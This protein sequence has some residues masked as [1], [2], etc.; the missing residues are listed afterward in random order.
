MPM[1]FALMHKDV[2]VCELD[3]VDG[4]LVKVTGVSSF[5]H[6]PLG[7][8]HDGVVDRGRVREWWHGRSIPASRYG[9]AE[10]L[11]S[12][13]ISNPLELLSKSMGLSLSDHYWISSEGSGIGWSDVNFY[14]HPFSDDV[15]DILFGNAPADGRTIDMSSPDNTSDGQLR[16]RWKIVNGERRLI[17]GGTG[18]L[19]QEPFNEAIA[20]A[21]MSA[22]GV[23][24]VEYEVIWIG[25][26]PYYSCKGFIGPATELLSANR[27]LLSE[28]R[29]NDVSVYDHF[30]DVCRVHGID[31]VPFLDRMIVVDYILCNGDRHTNNFGIIRDPDTLEWLRPAPVFDSGSSLGYDTPTMRIAGMDVRCKPFR[32]EFDRQLELVSDLSWFDDAAVRS[33]IPDIMNILE[34]SRGYID[35]ARADA[36]ADLILARTARVAAVR[37][38]SE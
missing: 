23:E 3:I 35:R 14:E 25:D 11:E 38:S 34:G 2:R 19:R 13:G 4:N 27:V 36:I 30:V 7:T 9:L 22:L 26:E 16:K 10:N 17:K 8:V 24:H 1:E 33:V 5:P 28:T 37:D 21:L 31:A 12:L 32:K 6:M 29:R 20:S 18:S 15:G